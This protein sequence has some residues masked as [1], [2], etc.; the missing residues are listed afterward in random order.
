[1]LR[2]PRL[3]NKILFTHHNSKNFLDYYP[4]HVLWIPDWNLDLQIFFFFVSAKYFVLEM[5][6]KRLDLHKL[7]V[8]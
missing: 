2:T 6:L 3:K 5:I 7:V 8:L 4:L 1:M